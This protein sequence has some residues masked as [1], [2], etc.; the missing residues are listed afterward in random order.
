MQFSDTTD[1][2]GLIEDITFL[3]GVNTG[4]YS[5]ADRTRNMNE[6]YRMVWQMI[7]ESYGGWKFMDDNVSDASTGVP[8]ADQTITSSLGLYPFPV[9]GLTANGAAFKPTSASNFQKLLPLTHEEFMAM[10]GDGRFASNGVPVYYMLQGDIV[11]L[12]PTPNFTLASALRLY[13][14][15]GVSLFIATDT[16]KTPGFASIFHRML[17]VGGSLDYALA[18]QM[19][20]KV[21]SLSNLWVDYERRLRGFYSK[22][23]MDRFPNKIGPGHD[24]MDDL[25]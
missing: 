16:T 5:L 13:F 11:R 12:L 3:L 15:Q 18:R 6:R 17:S 1:K 10:G 21:V 24:L 9:A 25:T 14:D 4:N 2:Q 22:R 20:D 23:F 19:Q 7:F 8:Y